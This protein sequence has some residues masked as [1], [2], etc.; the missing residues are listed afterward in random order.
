[1]TLILIPRSSKPN[2][3]ENKNTRKNMRTKEPLKGIVY[4]YTK[5]KCCI[6]R[7]VLERG[8]MVELLEPFSYKTENFKKVTGSQEKMQI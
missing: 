1:M 5:N 2:Q 8:A 7:T 4:G 3:Q 6:Q